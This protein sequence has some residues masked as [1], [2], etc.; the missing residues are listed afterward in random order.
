MPHLRQFI[1]ARSFEDDS[2][3]SVVVLTGSAK[4]FSAGFDLKDPEGR[5]RST[6]DL[7]AL[8][9]AS[10]SFCGLGMLFW[11]ISAF[12][13]SKEVSIYGNNTNGAA[14]TAPGGP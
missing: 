1:A 5:S 11:V 12:L 14:G 9:R 13:P 10:E 6:M 4:V 7:G 3:I 2:D 8:R